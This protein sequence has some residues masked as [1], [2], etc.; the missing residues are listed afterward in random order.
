MDAQDRPGWNPPTDTAPATHTAP[1]PGGPRRSRVGTGVALAAIGI[2]AI[3][4]AGT[5]YASSAS[6]SPV[7]GVHNVSYQSAGASG[8]TGAA[9]PHG[10]GHGDRMR[11]PGG[12]GGGPRGLGGMGGGPGFGMGLGG[13]V[14][15]SVSVPTKD[16][17]GYQ[18]LDMQTGIVD[19]VDAT[20]ISVTSADK[21][22]WTYVVNAS[23][24]VHAKSAGITSIVKGDTVTV[25]AVEN[26]STR[27]ALQ[28]VDRTQVDAGR[29]AWAPKPHGG[30]T[31]QSGPDPT[32]TG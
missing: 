32:Q 29:E 9:G 27:T 7:T 5:A 23:T 6:S 8:A 30:P 14:R 28:V 15:G 16:G 13:A 10:W 21:V 3:G 4:I 22:P 26:G 18:T 12:M 25:I 20:S 24:L 1:K 19:S 11:G 17:N 2:G 31:G